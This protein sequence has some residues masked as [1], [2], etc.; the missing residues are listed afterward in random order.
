MI[1]AQSK[2]VF[3]HFGGMLALKSGPCFRIQPLKV[4]FFGHLKTNTYSKSAQFWVPKNGTM[5]ARFQKWRP[6]FS[7]Q[8][9]PKSVEQT[10]VL[11]VYHLCVNFKPILK[12]YSFWTV[13]GPFYLEQQT[14]IK[15]VNLPRKIA[16]NK[17]TPSE[18]DVAA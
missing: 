15:S 13:F 1:N 5:G 6:L 7:C 9:P 18:T 17:I 2:R 4:L 11:C 16:S 8:Y 12:F 3:H 10:F 14:K